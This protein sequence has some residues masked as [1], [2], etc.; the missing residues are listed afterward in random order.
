MAD[1]RT[2]QEISVQTNPTKTRYS[3]GEELD[4]T[5]GVLLVTYSDGNITTVDMTDSAVT[6]S[7]YDSQKDGT[8]TVKLSYSGKSTE[9]TVTVEIYTWKLVGRTLS[10]QDIIYELQVRKR[11]TNGVEEWG[12]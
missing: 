8:Q 12:G 5:G 11:I 6:S 9:I 2:V 3:R 1:E 4:L 10:M 7:G